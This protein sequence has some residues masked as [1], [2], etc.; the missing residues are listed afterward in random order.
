MVSTQVGK[1]L[2]GM[3]FCQFILSNEL[4]MNFK[5]ISRQRRKHM[6]NL[7]RRLHPTPFHTIILSDILLMVFRNV[8]VMEGRC[9]E[10]RASDKPDKVT[11]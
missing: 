9:K 10:L 11:G 3:M 6:Q 8:K 5:Y 1:R 2:A 4:K 7:L